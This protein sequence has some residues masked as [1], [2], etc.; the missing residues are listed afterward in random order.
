MRTD[1]DK[2]VVFGGTRWLKG[3][4]IDALIARATPEAAHHLALLRQIYEICAIFQP[5]R[6]TLTVD[7]LFR[8]HVIASMADWEGVAHS[9]TAGVEK[10]RILTVDTE[11]QY[12]RKEQRR[13]GQPHPKR[14]VY[15]L[16]ANFEGNA[17]I[18]DLE[19]MAGGPVDPQA[20]L[21]VLPPP[22]RRWFV[23][24][25]YL[26]LG[27]AIAHD[28]KL[29]N[30]PATSVVDMGRV[31][32]HFVSRNDPSAPHA[33]I[34][35]QNIGN[36]NG[37]AVVQL[38]GKGFM[39][40]AMSERDYVELMGPHE[41]TNSKNKSHWPW[42]RKR[43]ILFTWEKD[44][45]FLKPQTLHY[46]YMDATGPI[47][48]LVRL[49]LDYAILAGSETA[50][51]DGWKLADVVRAFIEEFAADVT[52]VPPDPADEDLQQ[53]VQLVQQDDDY[54]EEHEKGENAHEQVPN[55][56]SP[57]KQATVAL[58]VPPPKVFDFRQRAFLAYQEQPS[59]GKRCSFCASA[60]HFYRGTTGDIICPV[61][62]SRDKDKNYCDYEYCGDPTG[63]FTKVC[64]FLHFTCSNCY[65]R[66]HDHTAECNTWDKAEWELRKIAWEAVANNGL[67]SKNRKL[68]WEFG[69]HAHRMYTSWPWPFK[70]YR[71]FISQNT[72]HVQRVLKDFAAGFW[73]EASTRVR[74][75]FHSSIK[76]PL[77]AHSSRVATSLAAGEQLACGKSEP[78][79]GTSKDDVREQEDEAPPAKK[80]KV[81]PIRQ[82]QVLEEP[83]N[84]GAFA[85]A[86]N[87]S[88][89]GAPPAGYYSDEDEEGED[90]IV[91]GIVPK[92]EFPDDDL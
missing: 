42:W 23:H 17:C 66:G 68:Q 30:I 72:V 10:Y 62:K 75:R 92:E 77:P 48:M 27:S 33:L 9:F 13:K 37:M 85:G 38:Y 14:V 71:E 7:Q 74:P 88:Y 90:C 83:V 50:F 22:F 78:R 67:Y 47:S 55:S 63:H 58:H 49:I 53:E 15:A 89:L 4:A 41:Y 32:D 25:E 2:R 43:H 12:P 40:K 73:P 76:R 82:V 11:S 57:S 16:A 21:A 20:P 86:S 61:Y 59:F 69:F 1:P 65:C 36:K 46:L 56:P 79:A 5:Y 87:P 6:D 84:W 45:G 35:L 91:V 26:I 81:H 28:F 64:P 51:P 31:F 19:A 80:L 34:K 29:A 39:C 24:R 8:T 70:T 44:T 60:T 54:R 3:E 52:D 18:F